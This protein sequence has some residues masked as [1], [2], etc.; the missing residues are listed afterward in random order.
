VSV[1]AIPA[2]STGASEPT[3][4]PAPGTLFLQF[5]AGDISGRLWLYNG[6][7]WVSGPLVN[8]ADALAGQLGDPVLHRAARAA[9]S[10]GAPGVHGAAVG[11]HLERGDRFRH[12]DDRG[13]PRPRRAGLLVT[14]GPVAQ[15]TIALSA[16]IPSLALAGTT[17]AEA[18]GGDRDLHRPAHAARPGTGSADRERRR[19]AGGAVERLQRGG[20]RSRRTDGRG[21]RHG[22]DGELDRA[23]LGRRA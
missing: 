16:S 22:S 8:V 17:F 5:A 18:V 2:A 7:Q 10:C 23:V 1:G 21:A 19:A 4:T 6:E 14:T 15:A 20:D 9:R 11:V 12:G 3:G 13:G